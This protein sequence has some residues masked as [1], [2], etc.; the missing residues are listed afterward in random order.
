[1][2]LIIGVMMVFMY[3]REVN[4]RAEIIKKQISLISG[5][6]LDAHE[7][8]VD[9]QPFMNFLQQYFDNSI[10]DDISVTVLDG[11]NNLISFIGEPIDIKTVNNNTDTSENGIDFGL[12]QNIINDD[13]EDR[14]FFYSKKISTDG[15]IQVYTAM[16]FTVSIS[17]AMQ[18][19][20]SAFWVLVILLLTA[21]T[22]IAY[23]STGFLSRN[24][25]ML[26]EFV[27]NANNK[28]VRFDESKFSH[29]EL[30]DI[31]RHIVKLYR[32]RSEA[33]A[34]SD[35]EHAIAIHAIEE[36]SRIKRQ[37]T[38]NINHELKTPVGVVRGY[39]DTV[40]T[41]DDM[42]EATRTYFLQRAKDNVERLCNLLN[43][44]SAM[45]RLEEGSSNI[46]MTELNF[47]DLVYTI[48]NDMEQ[49]GTLKGFKFNF[50]LPLDCVVKG[51]A[52]LLT[53]SIS[54]LIKNAVIHSGGDEIGI[55]LIA[56]SDQFY[57]FA[58]WDNGRGVKDEHLPHLFERFFRVDAGRSRKSGGTGL[59]LPIVKNTIEAMGGSISVKNRSQGGL[60]FD[61]TLKKWA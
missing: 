4:Y 33:L 42:D 61:F 1:M 36:Q 22:V 32:E 14:A 46:P 43:D 54:N 16:P 19:G 34:R 48:H 9:L 7:H 35:K 10:F 18:S 50:E 37:L 31:S 24:I 59:G 20:N 51:N 40:L 3:N 39:L 11:D 28:N 58:F 21:S 26:N 49:A 38:N 60:E 17:D 45:T 52:T 15:E 41:S 29:D 57:T 12:G 44:V 8:E 56:E 53:S 55:Y 6:V 27:K 30:G 5:R 25:E 47:H 2:W 13:N 23:F